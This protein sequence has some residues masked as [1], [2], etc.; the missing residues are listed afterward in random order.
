MMGCN[1]CGSKD[2]RIRF[3]LETGI[4]YVKCEGCGVIYQSPFPDI[5]QLQELYSKDDESYF[6]NEKKGVDYIRGEE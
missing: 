2:Y 3:Y 4:R 1:I 5:I 6:V